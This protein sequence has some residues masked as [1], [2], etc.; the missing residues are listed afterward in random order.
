MSDQT[1]STLND[2]Y[3]DSKLLV[4]QVCDIT[5]QSPKVYNY[6]IFVY[7]LWAHISRFLFVVFV[8]YLL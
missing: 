6:Y 2:R 8:L 4:S 3:A 7:D 5:E 1:E